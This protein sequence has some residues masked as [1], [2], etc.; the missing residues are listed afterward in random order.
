MAQVEIS[1]TGL[2]GTFSRHLPL[3]ST[4][5]YF[6][7]TRHTIYAFNMVCR[8]YRRHWRIRQHRIN[9]CAWQHWIN[10]CAV[11]AQRQTASHSM[12]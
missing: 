10:R 11:K 7:P 2:H 8:P 4:F 6:H 9:W 3:A 12:S 5:W 1:S